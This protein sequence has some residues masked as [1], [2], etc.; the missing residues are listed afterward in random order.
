MALSCLAGIFSA[1]L[2]S[3][4]KHKLKRWFANDNA[5]ILAERAATVLKSISQKV[6][7]CVV[8]ALLATWCNAWCTTKRFQGRMEAFTCKICSDCGGKDSVEHYARCLYQWQVFKDRIK[9]SS[10][11]TLTNFLVLDCDEDKDMIFT[12]VTSTLLSEQ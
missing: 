5:T 2:T 10:A 6:P 7:P 8:F 3:L 9:H 11:E 1:L 4:S 12:L